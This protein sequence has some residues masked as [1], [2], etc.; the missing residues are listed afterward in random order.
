M[1]FDLCLYSRCAAPVFFICFSAK[2]AENKCY[3]NG[4]RACIQAGVVAKIKTRPQLNHNNSSPSLRRGASRAAFPDHRIEFRCPNRPSGR[5]FPESRFDQSPRI[6]LPESPRI[7]FK[8]PDRSMWADCCASLPTAQC[9][10]QCMYHDIA[11]SRLF[12]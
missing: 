6:D 11:V 8:W 1:I 7:E 4:R 2:V 9:Q 10:A 12:G 5:S 3:K